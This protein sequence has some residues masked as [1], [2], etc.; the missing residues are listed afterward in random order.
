MKRNKQRHLIIAATKMRVFYNSKNLCKLGTQAAV[1]ANV[2]AFGERPF[3]GKGGGLPLDMD[4]TGCNQR[5]NHYL[6]LVLSPSALLHVEKFNSWL[7]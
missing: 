6:F 4:Q 2:G 1:V 3:P 5:A 7:F